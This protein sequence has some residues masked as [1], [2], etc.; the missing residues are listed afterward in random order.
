M[1]NTS[2]YRPVFPAG[3][4]F[5]G[6]QPPAT[7]RVDPPKPGNYRWILCKPAGGLLL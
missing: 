5:R 1:D 4:R 2:D 3:A 7:G 6:G